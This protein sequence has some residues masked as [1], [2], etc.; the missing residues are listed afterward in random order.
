MKTRN[1]KRVDLAINKSMRQAYH[2][3][4]FCTL[5]VFT[6]SRPN[7]GTKNLRIQVL[8]LGKAHTPTKAKPCHEN[9]KIYEE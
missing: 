9:N 7:T 4:M 5:R 8:L 6:F 1:I 2:Q 3:L